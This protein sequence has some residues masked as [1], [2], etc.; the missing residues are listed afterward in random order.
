MKTPRIKR[1]EIVGVHAAVS[2]AAAALA[3]SGNVATA[4][5]ALQNAL[6]IIGPRAL[7]P[8]EQAKLH[9]AAGGRNPVQFFDFGG[10]KKT[11]KDL[12]DLAGCSAEAMRTRLKTYS[13]EIAVEM[14]KADPSRRP[15]GWSHPSAKRYTF[16]GQQLTISELAKLAGCKDNTMRGRLKTMEAVEAVAMGAGDVKRKRPGSGN[17]TPRG[18]SASSQAL[19][20]KSWTIKER[21]Q[22]DAKKPAASGPVIVPKGL[23]IQRAPKPLDRFHIDP[24]SVPSH[25]GRIGQ[26]ESTGSAIEAQYR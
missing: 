20:D 5:Q 18:K 7:P 6:A 23:V 14:G 12:A 21:K 15:E 26:Y 4:Q 2:R 25:F 11:V 16:N 3:E 19:S 8:R 10:E 13:P 1:A 22:A 9:G 24:A 17:F